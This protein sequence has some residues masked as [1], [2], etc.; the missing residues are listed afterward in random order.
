MMRERYARHHPIDRRVERK[1]GPVSGSYFP[2][3]RIKIIRK[4]FPVATG[5]GRH[6]KEE[7]MKSE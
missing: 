3:P 2:A 7:D 1:S 6:V 5:C 4:T